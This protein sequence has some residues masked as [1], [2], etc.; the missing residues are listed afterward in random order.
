MRARK[1]KETFAFNLDDEFLL[2]FL[3][4]IER[5]EQKRKRRDVYQVYVNKNG[6]NFN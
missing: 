4:K 5:E 2:F 3:R 6:S 1:I